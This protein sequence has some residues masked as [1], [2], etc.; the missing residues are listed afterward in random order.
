M[1][2]FARFALRLGLKLLGLTVLAALA[3][4][5]VIAFGGQV[6]HHER[7]IAYC[8]RS[9]TIEVEFAGKKWV[10]DGLSGC[11]QGC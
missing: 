2:K 10:L 1:L 3:F 6:F 4:A 5:A 9:E 7:M 8:G 11:V